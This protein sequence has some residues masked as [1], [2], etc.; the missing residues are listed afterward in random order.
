MASKGRGSDIGKR[1][2]T[3]FLELAVTQGVIDKVAAD[4]RAL[5][6]LLHQSVDFARMAQASILSRAE[7]RKAVLAVAQKCGFSDLTRKFL[8]VLADN[9]RLADL[10]VILDA[11]GDELALRKG[12]V[13]AE[14]TS[15]HPLTAEQVS[16]MEA[17]LK[18]GLGKTVKLNLKQDA[19]LLGGLMVKVGSKMIDNSVR[20]RLD[21]LHRALKGNNN[22]NTKSLMKEVA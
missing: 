9:R 17:A 20:S 3:A 12:E 15:A 21:R 13:T 4:V 5:A 8:G 19:S 10:G 7:Q 6:T 18:K 11:V 1:Y 16:A 14:I 22:G 2:A